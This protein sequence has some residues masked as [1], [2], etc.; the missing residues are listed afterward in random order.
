MIQRVTVLG[1]GA[2]GT[3]IASLLAHKGH[4]VLVW[5]REPEIAASINNE[6]KNCVYLSS[7]VLPDTVTATNDLEQALA[8][9][10]YIFETIPVAFLRATMRQAR[11][12]ARPDQRWILMSKGIENDTYALPHAILEQ[13]LE[14]APLYAVLAGPTFA[15]ELIERHFTAAIL[16][17]TSA[18]LV[19]ELMPMITSDYFQPYPSNDPIGVEVAG[20]IKNVLAL[21]IGIAQG[22]GLHTNT[23]AYLLTQGMREIAELAYYFDGKSE[24]IYGLAG[25]GDIVLTC[26]GSL[27]KNLQAGIL[28][29]E[30]KTLEQIKQVIPTLPEGLNTLTSLHA[31]ISRVG[32]EFPIVDATYQFIYG[33]CSGDDFLRKII[34][35]APQ[36]FQTGC[37][38]H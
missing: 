19:K 38:A 24:T 13:E 30:G 26:T 1:A 22:I 14:H 20:A 28:L 6:H 15:K 17:S 21:A 3:A 33:G 36:T 37:C 16:A 23:R 11:S 4:E 27:S 5:C 2:F 7:A 10:D 31:F 12:Y 25:L 34:V 35:P 29:G 8:F 9:S 32:V 18:A